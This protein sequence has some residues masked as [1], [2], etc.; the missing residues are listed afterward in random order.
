MLKAYEGQIGKIKLQQLPADNSIQMQDKSGVLREQERRFRSTVGSVICLCQERYDVTFT[1]KD[2]ALKKSMD[3]CLALKVP[4]AVEGYV[5]KGESDWCLETFS[6]ADWSG[7]K[8]HRKSTPGGF[9]ALNSC[10]LFNSRRTQKI[11]SF[12]L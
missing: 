2:L 3:Y 10:P 4:Q 8:S 1:A 7:N 5:K 11:I 12:F 9:H 6:D